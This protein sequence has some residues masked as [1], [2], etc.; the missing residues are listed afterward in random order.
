MNICPHHKMWIVVW[1]QW[2]WRTFKTVKDHF[3]YPQFWRPADRLGLSKCNVGSVSVAP[4]RVSFIIC[5]V[6]IGDQVLTLLIERN[7]TCPFR[8]TDSCTSSR[9]PGGI[10]RSW[11]RKMK[12]VV[13]NDRS[14]LARL[15]VNCRRSDVYACWSSELERMLQ[16]WLDNRWLAYR[17]LTAMLIHRH[18]EQQLTLRTHENASQ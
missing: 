7:R 2:R 12:C 15:F 8:I 14:I 16:S 18:I 4:V 1:R 10:W 6:A 13:R 9:S 3:G 17:Q 11:G 5:G